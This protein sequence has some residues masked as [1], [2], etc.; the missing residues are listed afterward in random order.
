MGSRELGKLLSINDPNCS[1]GKIFFA[2]KKTLKS[3]RINVSESRSL[4]FHYG[5][6]GSHEQA[7]STETKS[8]K[9]FCLSQSA[10]KNAKSWATPQL[11]DQV[12]Y[13]L[14]VT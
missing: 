4:L 10:R 1:R 5:Y 6:C 3:V 2:E 12:L 13:F 7:H 9:N 8:Q 14:V 11:K